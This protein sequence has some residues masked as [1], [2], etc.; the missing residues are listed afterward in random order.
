MGYSFRKH[1]KQK[2]RIT[3]SSLAVF[4]KYSLLDSAIS[5]CRVVVDAVSVVAVTKLL[6]TSAVG[7]CSAAA[8]YC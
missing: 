2:S 7:C 1:F 5:Q 3:F 8:M 4:V 6:C